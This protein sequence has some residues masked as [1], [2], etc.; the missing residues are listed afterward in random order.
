MATYQKFQCFTSDLLNKLHDL[1]GS[2][3]TTADL[4]KVY[5]TDAT[6]NLATNTVKGDLADITNHNGYTG[7]IS[8]ANLGT[9]TTGT[10]T[11]NGTN[12]VVTATGGT[13]GPFRYVVLYNFTAGTVPL[14]CMWDYAAELTLNDSES[15]TL[16][17]NS[18]VA[19]GTIFTLG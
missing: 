16:K 10:F 12:I 14:I 11:L 4:L 15:I 5:L 3:G 18:G 6:P 7:P 1:L 17:F 2:G 13:V 9:V 8:V 19:N